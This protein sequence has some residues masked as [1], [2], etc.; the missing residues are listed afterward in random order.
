MKRI[1]ETGRLRTLMGCSAAAIITTSILTVGASSALA[2][3]QPNRGPN[4]GQGAG[5]GSNQTQ[6]DDRQGRGDRG[7]RGNREGRGGPGGW[8]GDRGWQGR[9]RDGGGG[10]EGGRG[11]GPG[12]GLGLMGTPDGL[13]SPDFM[14]R[15]APLVIEDLNLDDTQR[16]IV[17]Q[18]FEDYDDNFRTLVDTLRAET[19]LLNE[20]YV[21]DPELEASMQQ[22]RESMS[23]MRDEMRAARSQGNNPGDERPGRGQNNQGR[24]QQD[25]GDN[26]AN[27]PDQ[28]GQRNDDGGEGQEMTREQ[29][30]EQ[31][32]A[33]RAEF[34]L[35]FDDLHDQMRSVREKRYAS[36]E[37][38]TLLD[39]RVN[40]IRAFARDK[41]QLRD[42]TASG[43]R[44]LLIEDQTHLWD[45]VSR[46]LRRKRLM[47]RGRLSGES[48][49]LIEILDDMDMED[50][51][52]NEDLIL[53]HDNYSLDLDEALKARE[54][55]KYA[56]GL[57]LMDHIRN[58]DF[59]QGIE[60]L[61]K[62]LTLQEMT[63]DV[64]DQYI[65][66]MTLVLPETA[67]TDFRMRALRRGYSGVFRPTRG[68]RVLLSAME[69]EDLDPEILGAVAELMQSHG[70]EI[71]VFNEDILVI[72]RSEES[73]RELRRA[74]D[75]ISRFRGER[76]SRD[77]EE[78]DP[79]RE[80]YEKRN[81]IDERYL[82]TLESLLTAEQFE[83][84]E[85]RRN[86]GWGRGQRDRGQ[87]GEGGFSRED[88]IGQFDKN[89]DGQLDD[90]ERRAARDAMRE[91]FRGGGGRN[92]G[93]S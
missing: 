33:L 44:A 73:A 81:Q 12:R 14:T 24:G 50:S 88:F 25:R 75:R 45:D 56:E 11:G 86:R 9:G 54:N 38:Q 8:W 85:G 90:D 64:N 55:F 3:D 48:T 58:Q 15:D 61:R 78:F 74:E 53:L 21:P 40:L 23:D 4:Q 93:G 71:A 41:Q 69:I 7:F 37:M 26:D 31:A 57:D 62:Q 29:R 19:E 67:G 2:Q 82:A 28:V 68:E 70:S 34:R 17:A 32:E 27:S 89:G 22:V 10:G 49:D 59:N 87:G 35:K 80:A 63:R 18:L 30:R 36:T 1:P 65:E 6:G 42:S 60:V 43:I 52:Q 77:R 39:A 16:A 84:I 72:L 51:E 47:S 5:D 83:A 66:A 13:F 91:R 79:V 76:R 20:A 92:E 46:E